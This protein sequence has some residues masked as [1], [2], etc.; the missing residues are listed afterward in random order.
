LGLPWMLIRYETCTSHTKGTFHK[1]HTSI[2]LVY[3]KTIFNLVHIS[4]TLFKGLG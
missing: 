3:L 1:R 2:C 4:F